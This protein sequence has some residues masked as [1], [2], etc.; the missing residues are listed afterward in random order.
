MAIADF[1]KGYKEEEQAGADPS[2][3][4]PRTTRREIKNLSAYSAPVKTGEEKPEK[5][6]G[7]FDPIIAVGYLCFIVGVC[8]LWRMKK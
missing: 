3:P 8:L 4:L 5:K 7:G 1:F 2:D 6:R